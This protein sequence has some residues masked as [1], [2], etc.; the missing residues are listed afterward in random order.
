[1]YPGLVKDAQATAA[2][3]ALTCEVMGIVEISP[4]S[5]IKDQR[6]SLVSNLRIVPSLDSSAERGGG[7][8]EQGVAIWAPWRFPRLSA[9]CHAPEP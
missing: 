2:A 9:A 4:A 6:G 5:L 3:G 7:R 8:E 1:M